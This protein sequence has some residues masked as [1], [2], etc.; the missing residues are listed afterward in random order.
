MARA[1]TCRRCAAAAPAPAGCPACCDPVEWQ[2]IAPGRRA[3]VARA[4]LPASEALG[5]EPAATRM[6]LHPKAERPRAAIMN[7][8]S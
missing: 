5:T 7:A 3:A 1:A 8:Y 6:L 2:T 4:S